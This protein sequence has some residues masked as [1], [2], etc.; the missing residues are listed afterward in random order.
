MGEA[1]KAGGAALG[2]VVAAA[3]SA[4]CCAGPLLA[5]TAGV[6]GVGLAGTLE[7]WRP[8][9]LG[10]TALFLGA[11]FVLLHREEAKA[12]GPEGACAS[13]RA[14]RGMKV[15]LWTATGLAVVL[16]A[17][18]AWRGAL[19]GQEAHHAGAHPAASGTPGTTASSAGAPDGPA[20]MFRTVALEVRG[21]T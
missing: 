16:A 11:G 18:P 12:C 6:S 15:T 4:L 19:P 8:W 20:S 7:P 2:A 17:S 10:A 5:V 3:G 1:L 14:R 13:P 9:F 21:M